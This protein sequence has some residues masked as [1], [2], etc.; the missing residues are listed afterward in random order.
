VGL[1]KE[2]E[3]S[4]VTG[5]AHSLPST[6]PMEQNDSK[7]TPSCPNR[8]LCIQQNSVPDDFKSY[9]SIFFDRLDRNVTRY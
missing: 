6:V 9:V 8:K 3:R 4:Y 2:H 5:R 1:V 7:E